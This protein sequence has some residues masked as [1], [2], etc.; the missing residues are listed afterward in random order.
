M[1]RVLVVEYDE[2]VALTLRDGLERL[3]DC[4]VTVAVN[5]DH[6]LEL[7]EQRPID[8]LITDYKMPG[9]DGLAL[10]RCVR[11][12]CPQARVVMVAGYTDDSLW[13][14]AAA[15]LVRSI[16]DR[17]AGLEDIRSAVSDA[18][19]RPNAPAHNSLSRTPPAAAS[20]SRDRAPC[21]DRGRAERSARSN[22]ESLAEGE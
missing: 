8:V 18:L 1:R 13:Q 22:D 4:E 14:R 3:P 15:G 19:G 2:N 5:G 9:L 11:E 12:L 16:L 7:C 6:A 17:P 21:A 10:A 20:P